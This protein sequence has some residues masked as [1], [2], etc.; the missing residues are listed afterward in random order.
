MS[1]Q[2]INWN[3]VY[4]QAIRLNG[5]AP[6]PIARTGAM[7]HAAIYDAVNSIEKTHKPY[8]EIIPA[9]PGADKEAAAVYAAYTVLTSDIVYPNANFPKSKDKNNSFFDAERKKA[10]EEL[11]ASGVS[12][13]SIG[14]GKELGIAAAQAIIQNRQAD[15][16]NDNTPY[17][18]G[19]QPGDW[20]PTGSGAPVTPNWGKVK[21]FSKTEIERFRP[22]RPAGF[23]TKQAL[24]ASVEYAAQVNEVKRLG[25]ANSSDRTQEQTDIALFWANDLDGTYKP[26]GQL[27]AITQIVSK[28]RGLSFSQNARLFALVGLALGDAGI[29]AWDAKYDTDLD[30]WR[31]ESAIQ[32]ADTDGNPG[33]IADPTWRPLSPNL[34][35]TRFSP[36]F[37]AYV[38][39]HATFGAIHAGILRNFFGTDNVT[40]TATSED[41]AARGNNGIRITRT[42][43]SFSS[44][45]LEN[46]RS[47]IYLGV[48]YQ[49]DADAAYVSGTKLADFVSENFL[50]PT[51]SAVSVTLKVSIQ[52]L[53]PDKG[54]FLTPLWVG[55]HNGK[56]EIY[57][58]GKSLA[59]PKLES[60]VE[61]GLTEPF[62]KFFS[63]S[64]SGVVQGTI[65]GGPARP[66][67]PIA[68]GQT[69][70]VTLTVDKSSI[71]TSQY[72]S[73]ATMVIPSN[74][75]FI[76]NDNP[77]Q[78]KIFD[79]CGNFIPTSFVVTG[80]EVN[81]AG[82]E[83]NDENPTN[84]AFFG[85][86]TPNTGVPEKGVVLKH[87]GFIPKGP[88]LSDPR[89]VNADFTATGYKIARITIEKA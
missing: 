41:P 73:Y 62:S 82:T 66:I 50:T 27:Y 16:Y 79:E 78:Y 51:S 77:L 81:D 4:L 7:L 56:F 37:P 49:W 36:P 54:T 74:D 18:P 12:L 46:G 17:T 35:G 40:F 59:N 21:P 13:Q 26:P 2:V 32:L 38:S 67:A 43:N 88:I 30:L 55:L 63:E 5:G 29:L 15:G 69:A 48:H 86:M 19:N 3:N 39:G 76:A 24:L 34:D 6:G 28:L 14:D 20:R 25:F 45:A 87:P 44:A 10:I 52:N 72:F 33:T 42:F 8:L 84:T 85:Q 47:R 71:S 89:F 1:D 80:A 53:A 57:D 23:K 83:V 64:G 9:N 70:S 11:E 68:P 31:P 58:K 65:F 22:T 61:D 60:L 75:A